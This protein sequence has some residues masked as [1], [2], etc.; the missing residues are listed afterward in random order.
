MTKKEHC[1]MRC[2]IATFC[3]KPRTVQEV[4]DK[5]KISG[6]SAGLYLSFLRINGI[7]NY[8]K[9]KFTRIKGARV[10]K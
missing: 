7:V 10:P 1:E 5:F 9:N 3:T 8:E 2:K 6:A 4:R